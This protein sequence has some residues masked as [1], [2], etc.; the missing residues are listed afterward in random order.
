MKLPTDYQEA[1][2]EERPAFEAL[3]DGYYLAEVESIKL[4][5]KPGPSG[6]HS[7][8]IV[9]RILAPRASAKL[10]VW[11][12]RSLSPKASFKMRDL[13][14]ALGYEYDSDS[15]ELIGEKAVLEIIQEEIE[16][17]PRKGE[18]GNS[19]ENTYAADDP[20]YRKLVAK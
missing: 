5:D 3:D 8:V 9:W 7:W 10:T 4:S 12:R 14:D 1:M 13:Y 11:D 16:K 2:G 18:M 17:G 20:E 19:V 6:Y 15:D